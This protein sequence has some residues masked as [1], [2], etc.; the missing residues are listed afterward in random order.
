MALVQEWLG[1]LEG[2]LGLE[3]IPTAYVRRDPPFPTLCLWLQPL[4]K[5]A[6]GG[7]NLAGPGVGWL[8]HFVHSHLWCFSFL[9]LVLILLQRVVGKI[10]LD[11]FIST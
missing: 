3:L 10:K 4:G 5:T 8:C 6:C 2:R 1:S 7:M 11:M 9:L